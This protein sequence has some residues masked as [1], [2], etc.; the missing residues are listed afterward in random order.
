MISWNEVI[1]QYQFDTD[2]DDEYSDPSN[3][4]NYFIN[5][6]PKYPFPS[7]CSDKDKFKA[8]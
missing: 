7:S 4:C 3:L 1:Q 6:Y 5:I 8:H 2:E